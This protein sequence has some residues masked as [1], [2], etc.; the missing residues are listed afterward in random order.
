MDAQFETAELLVFKS[1]CNFV[2]ELGRLYERDHTPLG[3]Y[4]KLI[5]RTKITHTKPISK[6]VAAFKKWFEDNMDAVKNQNSSIISQDEKAIIRYSDAVYIDMRKIF[7][8]SD[9]DVHKV[10]W[11]HLHTI[12]MII[13]GNKAIDKSL[14]ASGGD[15]NEK[16]FIADVMKKVE[17][18][19]DPNADPSQSLNKLVN[20]GI[21]TDLLSNMNKGLGDGSLDIGRLLSMT[22]G[23]LG[24]LQKNLQNIK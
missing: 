13:N 7:S 6:H 18:N 15:G 12:N 9:G 14:T 1:I 17:S 23:M 20:S 3:L 8:I 2:T 11:K 5:L 22:T 4:K 16:D 10:I 19:I 24:G 21:F